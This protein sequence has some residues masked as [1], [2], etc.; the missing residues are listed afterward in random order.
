MQA[1]YCRQLVKAGL[2]LTVSADTWSLGIPTLHMFTKTFN[3]GRKALLTVITKCKYC[4][5]T[6]QV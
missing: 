1:C 5:I 2:L 3:I 4:Q 6:E